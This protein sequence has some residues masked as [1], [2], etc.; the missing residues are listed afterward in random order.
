MTSSSWLGCICY[1]Y[2]PVEQ[3]LM[4]L[5]RR[6]CWRSLAFLFLSIAFVKR[7]AE[8]ERLPDSGQAARRGYTRHDKEL[9]RGLGTSSGYLCVLVLALYIHNSQDVPILYTHPTV[10]WLVCPVCVVLD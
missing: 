9:L 1:A 10:L 7:Y 8:L 5:C 2:L 4:F 6:G 3:P